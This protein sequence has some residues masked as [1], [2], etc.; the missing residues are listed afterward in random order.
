[1]TTLLIVALRSAVINLISQ[2]AQA[3]VKKLI[4]RVYAALQELLAQYPASIPALCVAVSSLLAGFGFNVSA[5]TL[6]V[7][8]SA[9]AV[10]VGA[11]VHQ[12]G[13]AVAAR[14]PSE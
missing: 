12:S 13:K 5:N 1:M 9:V 3:Q 4:A 2:G 10:F 8:A 14:K 7:I 6:A 11:L